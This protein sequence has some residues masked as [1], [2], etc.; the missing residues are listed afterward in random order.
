LRANSYHFTIAVVAA[1]LLLP[2]ARARASASVTF[3]V[4]FFLGWILIDKGERRRGA[5]LA[6]HDLPLALLICVHSVAI[7]A[8]GR[9]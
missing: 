1:A 3:T 8:H 9:A 5:G 7:K 2:R 4:A 6:S